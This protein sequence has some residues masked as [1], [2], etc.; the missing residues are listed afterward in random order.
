[1][2]PQCPIERLSCLEMAI[3]S[4]AALV[5]PTLVMSALLFAAWALC[6]LDGG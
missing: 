4:V 3:A 6:F 1:M 5:V 2:K